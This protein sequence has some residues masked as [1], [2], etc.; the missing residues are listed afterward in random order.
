MN[1]IHFDLFWKNSNF[2]IMTLIARKIPNSFNPQPKKK[3]SL[4]TFCTSCGFH[5]ADEEGRKA[6]SSLFYMRSYRLALIVN[7]KAVG[8][9]YCFIQYFN[10]IDLI[11]YCS[12]SRRNFFM[13]WRRNC[14]SLAYVLPFF[15]IWY[16][17]WF[18]LLL[19]KSISTKSF[20]VI[21]FA[22]K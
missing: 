6:N 1:I 4:S 22:C 9:K 14:Q 17:L 2:V 19:L 15:T 5:Y 21:Q 10:N 8:I 16:S 11:P 3:F 13:K 20:E 7:V 18:S 12:T